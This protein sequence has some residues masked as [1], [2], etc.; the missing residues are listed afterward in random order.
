[1]QKIHINSP[2]NINQRGTCPMTPTTHIP[3]TTKIVTTSS[4]SHIFGYVNL[5]SA[6][7]HSN[8]APTPTCTTSPVTNYEQSLVASGIYDRS[9]TSRHSDA[10]LCSSTRM[11]AVASPL[12]LQHNIYKL[13]QDYEC[14]KAKYRELQ[15]QVEEM[16]REAQE[17]KKKLLCKEKQLKAKE[18]AITAREINQNERDEQI[19]LLK[20]YV[21][22]LELRVKDLD[23]QNKLLK[24]KLL[25]SEEIRTN[26]DPPTVN[27]GSCH[28]CTHQ[29]RCSSTYH[30]SD[31]ILHRLIDLLSAVNQRAPAPEPTKITNIYQPGKPNYN[32]RRWQSRKRPYQVYEYNHGHW[33]SHHQNVYSRTSNT[34]DEQTS[35]DTR[36][37][38]YNQANMEVQINHDARAPNCSR[39]EKD[40]QTRYTAPIETPE[41]TNDTQEKTKKTAPEIRERPKQ[42]ENDIHK[43]KA[44][45]S[46][47]TSNHL[48]PTHKDAKTTSPVTSKQQERTTKYRQ[49]SISTFYKKRESQPAGNNHIQPKHPDCANTTNNGSNMHGAEHVS[50]LDVSRDSKPPDPRK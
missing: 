40:V 44:Q 4:D 23:E 31:A 19:T 16:Q 2:D 12:N 27:H 15:C 50:F 5:Q 42:P 30:Q 45:V 24:L 3:Q 43:V 49:T 32:N 14:I 22:D 41:Q 33:S 48:Q 47:E 10:S 1:M 18:T 17:N 8:S 7:I 20:T 26:Q 36:A 39:V 29:T 11:D 9:P 35:Q 25:T 28:H 6:D 46:S 34:T 13:S 21:N 37:P 38:N